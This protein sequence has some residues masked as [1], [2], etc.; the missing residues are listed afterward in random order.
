MGNDI[1]VEG[2]GFSVPV[3]GAT[4]LFVSSGSVVTV[5]S[6]AARIA[7]AGGGFVDICGPAKLSLLESNGAF[8]VALNFGKVRVR[9][10]DPKKSVRIFTP[11]IIATPVAIS[12]SP[13]DFTLGLAANDSMC[14]YVYEGAGRL[15]Q[16]FGG[17]PLLVPMAGEFFLRSEKLNPVAGGKG[18][19]RCTEY[20]DRAA[21][22]RPGKGYPLPP[23]TQPAI[24]PTT[25]TAVVIPPASV[26][27]PTFT[28][29]PAQTV[30]EPNLAPPSAPPATETVVEIPRPVVLV[31]SSKPAEVTHAASTAPPTVP[32][33]NAMPIELAVVPPG[34]VPPD[35]APPTTP[36]P[37]AIA[38]SSPPA[39]VAYAFSPDA[40]R[41]APVATN[42]NQPP[43]SA[44]P[45]SIAQPGVILYMPPVA[46]SSNLP[47]PPA[48]MTPA[49]A[50]QLNQS[51]VTPD[52]VFKGHVEA[53]AVRSGKNARGGSATNAAAKS[54][55][56]TASTAAK[57]AAASASASTSTSASSSGASGTARASTA[58]RKPHGVWRRLRRFFGTPPAPPPAKSN[59]GSSGSQ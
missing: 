14:V 21:N 22:L 34:D 29:K 2:G 36:S 26:R 33:I 35:I 44:E 43:P 59:S 57:P 20:E 45:P 23:A 39:A 4:S 51:R 1:S 41:A 11:F 55:G 38:A 24:P 27:P 19:C 7:L 25:A 13:R 30:A 18:S 10:S 8:T 50:E 40:N 16:Q 53:A 58:P 6:G 49:L 3:P 37:A 12:T 17:D 15:E 32:E 48:E 31:E 54:G 47:E 28:A 9:L 56:A 52:W 5:H 46:Y 42:D